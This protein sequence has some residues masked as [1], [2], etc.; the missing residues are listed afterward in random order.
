MA[1]GLVLSLAASRG[2]SSL[3]CGVQ[4]QQRS[5]RREDI[6]MGALEIKIPG[7]FLQG[8][9]FMNPPRD[10]GE[11]LD[12]AAYRIRTARSG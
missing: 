2:H 6:K 3:C 7:K 5:G 4:M 9:D 11:S 8:T 10:C 1:P 12:F